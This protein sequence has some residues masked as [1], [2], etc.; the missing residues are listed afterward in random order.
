MNNTIYT[1]GIS[2][3]KCGA[4]RFIEVKQ[5]LSREQIEAIETQQRYCVLC[6]LKEELRKINVFGA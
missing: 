1:Y 6:G 2:C 3:R 5:R 4:T